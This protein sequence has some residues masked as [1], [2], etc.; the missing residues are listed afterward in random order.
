MNHLIFISLLID[1]VK[2]S[3]KILTPNLLKLLSV[4]VSSLEKQLQSPQP[5]SEICLKSSKLFLQVYSRMSLYVGCFWSFFYVQLLWKFWLK[6][7][8]KSKKF[9]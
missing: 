3:H 6:N 5:S 2:Q 9:A 4:A 7:S 1:E 8:L